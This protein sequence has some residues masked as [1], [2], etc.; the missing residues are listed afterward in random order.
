[1]KSCKQLQGGLQDIADMMQIKRVGRQHQAGSDSL[2]TGQVK[3]FSKKLILKV[4]KC[5]NE[6][7]LLRQACFFL[8][9]VA[10]AFPIAKHRS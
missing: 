3:R 2:L 9:A 6:A 8:S 7:E 1:M 10:Y 5:E 4:T